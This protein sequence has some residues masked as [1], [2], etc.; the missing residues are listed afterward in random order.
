MSLHL[1]AIYIR[2]INSYVA[3]L[4]R[5]RELAEMGAESIS[6]QV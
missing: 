3:V 6:I 4:D 1:P 2:S 5:Q